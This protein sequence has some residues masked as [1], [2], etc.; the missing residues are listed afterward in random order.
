MEAA[1]VLPLLS[2]TGFSVLGGH[3]L[4]V[5]IQARLEAQFP[6]HRVAGSITP[7]VFTLL[8]ASDGVGH[9]ILVNI[10][11]FS[12]CE[13]GESVVHK[14]SMQDVIAQRVLHQG[15]RVYRVNPP[16]DYVTPEQRKAP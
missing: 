7:F 12:G 1:A 13:L 16:T 6:F 3:H 9:M 4:D 8:P 15:A 2:A 14:F 5:L 11:T 10:S